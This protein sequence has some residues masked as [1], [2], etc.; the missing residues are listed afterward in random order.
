MV[1]RILNFEKSIVYRI[2]CKDQTITRIYIGSSVNFKQRLYSHKSICNNQTSP[3]YNCMLYT[4]IRDNGGWGNFKMEVI[5]D[6]ICENL[7]ELHR[8]ERYYMDVLGAT[9]NKR[10]PYKQRRI[11]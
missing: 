7:R 3:Y 8:K 9:L 1:K 11:R 6:V 10:R 4:Y 5:E 2:S